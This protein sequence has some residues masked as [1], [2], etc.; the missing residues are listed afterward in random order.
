MLPLLCHH[1]GKPMAAHGSGNLFLKP[2]T[3]HRGSFDLAKS[4]IC[5]PLGRSRFPKRLQLATGGFCF[6]RLPPFDGWLVGL[7]LDCGGIARLRRPA[8]RPMRFDG[9]EL[10]PT[11]GAAAAKSVR[12][13]R[14]TVGSWCVLHHSMIRIAAGASGFFTLIQSGDLPDRYGRSR[15]LATMP[16]SPSAQACLNTISPSAPSR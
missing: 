4:G 12:L 1:L 6:G 16:S 10:L 7:D 14:T 9:C 5:F 3:V 15:R 8:R 11:A 13:P 2:G